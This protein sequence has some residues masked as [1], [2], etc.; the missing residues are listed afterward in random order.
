MVVAAVLLFVALV[1]LL[2]EPRETFRWWALGASL[3]FLAFAVFWTAPLKPVNRLW[4]ALGRLLY[5]AISPLALGMLFYGAVTPIGLLMRA[6]GKDPLRLRR[7][8]HAA[9]YWIPRDPPG[10]PPQSMKNQ[11]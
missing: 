5:R 6:L 8:A 1:P 10:P 9:S 11:F 4:A 7:D 3:L 2:R